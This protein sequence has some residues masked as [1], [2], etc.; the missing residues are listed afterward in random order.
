MYGITKSKHTHRRQTQPLNRKH[1]PTHAITTKKAPKQ[2]K[3]KLQHTTRCTCF[4]SSLILESGRS[5]TGEKLTAGAAVPPAVPASLLALSPQAS[6]EAST[7]G[8][9]AFRSADRSRSYKQRVG[10]VRGRTHVLHAPV[11][12]PRVVQLTIFEA[13]LSFGIIIHS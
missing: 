12:R 7:R 2:K 6:S 5:A 8:D 4:S 9:I 10:V 3:P 1:T 13:L 11:V